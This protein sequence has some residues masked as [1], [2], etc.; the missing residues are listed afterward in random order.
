M[1]RNKDGAGVKGK[2][3]FLIACQCNLL[4]FLK[5]SHTQNTFLCT[6]SEVRKKKGRN[7]KRK[8]MGEK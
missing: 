5:F 6:I 3:S 7:E 4:L 2:V 1:E 8:V